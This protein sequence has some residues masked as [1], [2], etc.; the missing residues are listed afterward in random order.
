MSVDAWKKEPVPTHRCTVC[1]ALW[2]YSCY[3]DTGH[4]DAWKLCSMTAEACC[5]IAPMK[6]QIVVLTLGELMDWIYTQRM[7]SPAPSFFSSP[8]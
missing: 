7:T 5:D 3:R 4:K 6:E 2:R 1:G 8:H